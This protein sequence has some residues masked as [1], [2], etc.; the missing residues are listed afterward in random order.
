MSRNKVRVAPKPAVIRKERPKTPGELLRYLRE[1]KDEKQRLEAQESDINIEITAIE[2]SVFPTMM[3]DAD[4]D[5]IS[6][7]GIG[8]AK[9]GARVFVSVRADLRPRFFEWLRKRGNGSLIKEE[10]HHKTLEAFGRE[11]YENG[12]DYPDDLITITA[13]PAVTFRRS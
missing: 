13:I 1:L 5:K 10:V 6:E 8:S 9:L 7:Q 12:E 4:L 2:Q 3:Q 11:L